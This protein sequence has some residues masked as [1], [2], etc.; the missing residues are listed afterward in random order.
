M[1][2]KYTT[3]LYTEGAL[4][5]PISKNDFWHKTVSSKDFS[6]ILFDSPYCRNGNQIKHLHKS[7]KWV[8]NGSLNNH[9][10]FKDSPNELEH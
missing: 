6:S 5:K 7:V 10:I 9:Q 1:G 4:T 8:E 2:P 3:K